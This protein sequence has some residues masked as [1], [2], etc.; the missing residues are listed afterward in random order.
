MRDVACYILEIV[1]S[2]DVATTMNVSWVNLHAGVTQGIG[3]IC[4]RTE[5]FSEW[6]QIEYRG[7][8]L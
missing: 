5:E 4:V 8:V 6:R 3:I 1:S 7:R 2:N